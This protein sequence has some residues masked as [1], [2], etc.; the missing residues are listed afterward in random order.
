MPNLPTAQ[1]NRR[2]PT[3]ETERLYLRPFQQSDAAAYARIVFSNADVMRYLNASGSTPPNPLKRAKAV[4]DERQFEWH[5]RGYGAWAL[6][7]RETSALMGHAGLFHIEG[8]QIVEIG[9]ALGQNYW[10]QGYATEA[11][12]AVR[13]YAFTHV[14]KVQRDGLIAIAFPQN[15][16]SLRVM[17]KMGM[18]DQGLTTEFY[19]LEL[20]LYRMSYE[21]F[22]QVTVT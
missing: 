15:V 4:I 8:T 11:A 9:Y 16:P 6:V 1:P 5:Q 19:D 21:R 20:A 3:L 7:H 18:V 14:E 13:D 10:G 22:Q 12:I 17:E 2:F